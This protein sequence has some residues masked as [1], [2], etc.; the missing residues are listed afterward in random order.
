M[1]T[2]PEGF[3]RAFDEDRGSGSCPACC[4]DFALCR[5]DEL[6]VFAHGNETGVMAGRRIGPRPD[7][8][9]RWTDRRSVHLVQRLGIVIEDVAH[10]AGRMTTVS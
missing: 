10:E 6:E 4:I 9:F 3:C 5:C 1:T 7:N 8:N 2:S